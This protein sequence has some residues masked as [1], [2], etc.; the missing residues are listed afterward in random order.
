VNQPVDA[1]LQAVVNEM[2]AAGGI[3]LGAKVLP[4]TNQINPSTKTHYADLGVITVPGIVPIVP[5]WF[6][7]SLQSDL[8]WSLIGSN[9]NFQITNAQQPAVVNGFCVF[10]GPGGS[11]TGPAN[12]LLYVDPLSNPLT[13]NDPTQILTYVPQFEIGAFGTI[14]G[15]GTAIFN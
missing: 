7:A 4:Y 5:T 10:T 2:I 14:F 3:L 1:M 11:G 8:S 9:C 15:H 12:V 6:G 13:L